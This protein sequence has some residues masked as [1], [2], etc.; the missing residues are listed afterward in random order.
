MAARLLAEEGR[1]SL[2]VRRLAAE[3]GT[4]TMAVY[5]QFGG[6]DELRRAVGIDGFARL[7][8]HL[9]D[10]PAFRDPVAEL[11]ALGY[12]YCFNALSNPN[13]YRVMFQEEPID[14]SVAEAGAVAFLRLIQ[15]VER[16]IA[17]GRFRPADPGRL[18]TR[19]WTMTHGVVSVELAGLVGI[20]DAVDDLTAMASHLCAGFGDDP[21]R[22]E[23]SIQR[24]H[25]VMLRRHIASGVP[26]AR[27]A[28][29]AELTVE[30]A[31]ASGA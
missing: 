11:A 31:G 28:T 25:N 22:A 6:M 14:A 7:A 20:D 30:G 2:T 5:T 27:A 13:L 12:A 23:R 18:A 8:A 3:A 9:A 15:A 17:A 26:M 10:A 4:S 19:F 16:C 21:R 1:R 29:V 24:G